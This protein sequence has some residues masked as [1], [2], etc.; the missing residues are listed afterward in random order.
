LA[1][2]AAILS[3]NEDIPVNKDFVLQAKWDFLEKSDQLIESINA[4]KKQKTGFSTI[5]VSKYN[6]IALKNTGIKIELVAKIEDVAS[7]LLVVKIIVARKNLIVKT[8]SSFLQQ[9]ITACLLKFTYRIP[10]N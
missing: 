5:F 10:L 2:V 9:Q 6:K 7:M 8:S 4:F 3:S 1:V